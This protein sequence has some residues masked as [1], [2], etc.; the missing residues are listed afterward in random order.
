MFLLLPFFICRIF[1]SYFKKKKSSVKNI[2]D[3]CINKYNKPRP[4]SRNFYPTDF[5]NKNYPTD[6]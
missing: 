1:F 5:I 3:M 6:N 2:E 4:V